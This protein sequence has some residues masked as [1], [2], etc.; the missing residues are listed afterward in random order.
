[1][2]K[3][4]SQDLETFI[5]HSRLSADPSQTEAVLPYALHKGKCKNPLELNPFGVIFPTGITTGGI[6]WGTSSTNKSQILSDCQHFRSTLSLCASALLPLMN[7][8]YWWSPPEATIQKAS[9]D[10]VAYRIPPAHYAIL[11]NQSL[12]PLSWIVSALY[13]SFRYRW[14][15][16]FMRSKR[17]EYESCVRNW[18]SSLYYSFYINMQSTNKADI[19]I[20]MFTAILD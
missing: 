10:F 15:W 4:L 9:A 16:R 11:W 8:Q 13:I 6:Y 5:K 2:K 18:R 7:H 14:P 17:E 3:A 20:S 19:H 12:L 1:M